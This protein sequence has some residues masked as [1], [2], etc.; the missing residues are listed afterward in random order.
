MFLGY[1]NVPFFMGL[2]CSDELIPF[3]LQ[4]AICPVA[5]GPSWRRDYEVEVEDAAF[6]CSPVRILAAT[7][8]ASALPDAAAA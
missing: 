6:N 7:Y 2:E 4:L 8:L 1:G 3:V 5:L